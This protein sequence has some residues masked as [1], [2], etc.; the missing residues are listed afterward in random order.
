[1]RGSRDFNARI[2]DADGNTMKNAAGAELRANISI[3]VN[4][5]FFKKIIAFFKWLFRCLP[6]V[7]VGP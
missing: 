5:G 7:T 3:R 2:I 4:A 1:M 6:S